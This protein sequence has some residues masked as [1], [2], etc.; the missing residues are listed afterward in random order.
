MFEEEKA[1]ERRNEEHSTKKEIMAGLCHLMEL[2]S[3][4]IEGICRHGALGRRKYSIF[5]N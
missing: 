1:F 4:M 3:S 5:L 2:R